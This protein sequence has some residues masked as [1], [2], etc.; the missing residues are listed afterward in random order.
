MGRS[1][2]N[3]LRSAAQRGDDPVFFLSLEEAKRAIMDQWEFLADKHETRSMRK[4]K[5]A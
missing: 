2:S 3:R 4:N 5:L 1:R